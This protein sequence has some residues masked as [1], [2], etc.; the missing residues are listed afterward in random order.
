MSMYPQQFQPAP[1]GL[2]PMA[3]HPQAAAQSF[4]AFHGPQPMPQAPQR[5]PLQID[6]F[7]VG[8][9]DEA[10]AAMV[11]PVGMTAFFSF[12]EDRIYIK[13]L[14]NDGRAEMYTF[15]LEMPTADAAQNNPLD[16]INQRL[17][18]IELAIGGLANV[19][20]NAATNATAAGTNAIL[21]SPANDANAGNEQHPATTG[22]KGKRDAGG[23]K[24]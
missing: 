3:F 22:A 20:S 11:N 1:Y 23:E 5:Q 14:G 12:G 21:D 13:R 10:R 7:Q 17:E 15:R 4:R 24:S 8:S 9:I 2:N 6:T 18:R 16:T 19:Q